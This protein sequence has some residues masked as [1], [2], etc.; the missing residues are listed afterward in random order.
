MT[1]SR[2]WAN[3]EIG[4]VVDVRAKRTPQEPRTVVVKDLLERDLADGPGFVDEHGEIYRAF[5]Y[6]IEIHD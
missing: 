4:S 2:R 5:F 6:D 3:L 1:F